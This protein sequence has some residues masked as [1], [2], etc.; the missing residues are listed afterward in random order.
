MKVLT[1][2]LSSNIYINATYH[3]VS[4]PFW[5]Q[6]NQVVH[7]CLL[8]SSDL[9]FC[10][11]RRCL[12]LVVFLLL[13]WWRRSSLQKIWRKLDNCDSTESISQKNDW[14]CGIESQVS[15]FGVLNWF[16]FSQSFVLLDMN[17][18]DINLFKSGTSENSWGIRSPHS[19]NNYHSHVK[20]HN[21]SLRISWIPNSDC[22]I[23]RSWDESCWVVVIPLN[24]INCKEMTLISFLI[25]SRVGKWTFMNFSF[26]SADKEWEVIKSVEIEAK[27]ASKTN[28]RCFF[29]LFSSQFQSE[30]F[31][32]LELVF[33][34]TPVHDPTVWRNRVE[35]ELLVSIR[36]PSD[37]PDWI[38]VLLCSHCWFIDGFVM[39]VSN[40]IYKNCTIIQ[41][42]SK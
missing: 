6:G 1:L 16:L 28:K 40:V 20:D 33:H 38:S 12:F 35:V 30:N 41:S 19:I 31:F 13:L 2:W 32:R 26:F 29:L 8:E 15:Q 4:V 37:L 25:L 24:L 10:W 39:F 23:S 42:S 9:F 21:L 5:Y 36:I 18:I 27:T 14:I 11:W 3:S 17:I 22:P 7:L 34:Q